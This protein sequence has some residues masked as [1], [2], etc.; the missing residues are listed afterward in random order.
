MSFADDVIEFQKRGTVQKRCNTGA[1][2]ESLDD[3]GRKVFHSY[4]A[5]GGRVSN[6]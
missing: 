6:L 5:S 1:W 2:L 3:E 4:I